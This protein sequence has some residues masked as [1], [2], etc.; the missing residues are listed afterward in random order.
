MP[1][2]E[3]LCQASADVNKP[4]KDGATPLYA[5][6]AQVSMYFNAYMHVVVPETYV[7]IER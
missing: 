6:A 1:V 4:M 2:V 3:Y 7:K 5:A